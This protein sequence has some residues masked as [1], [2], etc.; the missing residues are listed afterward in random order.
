MQLNARAAAGTLMQQSSP[1]LPWA[2]VEPTP[3][4][5]PLLPPRSA[6]PHPVLH[7]TCST[8]M[9]LLPAALAPAN[10]I[11]C[12]PC[13]AYPAAAM[14]LTLPGP[15]C[16]ASRPTATPAPPPPSVSGLLMMHTCLLPQPALQEKCMALL[17]GSARP[18]CSVQLLQRGVCSLTVC[19]APHGRCAE[20]PTP[21]PLCRRVLLPR[22]RAGGR[23]VPGVQGAGVRRV[24]GRQ[25]QRVQ[26]VRGRGGPRQRQVPRR[27]GGRLCAPEVS[28][29]CADV[30]RSTP[31]QQRQQ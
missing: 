17:C 9:L 14:P 2:V 11:L 22:L 1:A 16:A 12:S 26:D 4:A 30:E 28:A 15:A 8:S 27:L 10:L 29:P 20:H 3:G 6:L 5:C 19:H 23:Q 21:L 31:F 25:D 7:L 24:Q 18:P 13:S